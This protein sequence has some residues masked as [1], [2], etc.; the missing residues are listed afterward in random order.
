MVR[1]V[2]VAAPGSG[3]SGVH[4][5]VR[6]VVAAGVQPAKADMADFVVEPRAGGRWYEVG[7]DGSVHDTGPRARLRAARAAR[8]RLATRR[9]WQYDPDLD[10]AGEVEVQFVAEGPHSTRVELE[11]RHFERHGD[12]APGCRRRRRRRRVD[13]LPRRL[14]QGGGLTG[15]AGSARPAPGGPGR[16]TPWRP[17]DPDAA[18]AAAEDRARHWDGR[19]QRRTRPRCPGSRSTPPCP[20]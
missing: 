17:M 3:P 20:R 19:Y 14:R 11:H 1:T 8:N 2:T 15:E 6:H 13:L 12:G 9:D 5:A 16:D 18:P 7:V 4:R 10:H